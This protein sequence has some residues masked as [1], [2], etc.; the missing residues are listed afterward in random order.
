MSQDN[1]VVQEWWFANAVWCD[2]RTEAK[3]VKAWQW[4]ETYPLPWATYVASI[5]KEIFIH[6]FSWAYYVVL[7]TYDATNPAVFYTLATEATST[8]WANISASTDSQ[9]KSVT[10]ISS[11]IEWG[12]EYLYIFAWEKIHRFASPPWATTLD[13][14]TFS[15]SSYSEHTNPVNVNGRIYFHNTWIFYS[16]DLTASTVSTLLSFTKKNERIIGWSVYN[17]LFRIYTTT[18]EWSWMYIWNGLDT[19]P[20]YSIALTWINVL[21]MVNNWPL[22]YIYSASSLYVVSGT[23]YKLVWKDFNTDWSVISKRFIPNGNGIA[24]DWL[25]FI[26]STS[27][28]YTYW[29]FYAWYPEGLNLWYQWSTTALAITTAWDYLYQWVST[30]LRTTKLTY[31]P[32]FYQW[33]DD[34][35]YNPWVPAT[36][37]PYIESQIYTWDES[38]YGLSYQKSITE[39]NIWY[40][41]ELWTNLDFYMRQNE[42][43]SWQLV[44]NITDTSWYMRIY[45]NELPFRDFNSIQFKVVFNTAYA[46]AVA[47]TPR[48]F[49]IKTIY[50]P[51]GI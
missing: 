21:W 3:C 32:K 26:P 4:C 33:F 38:W 46:A 20:S 41:L 47:D 9:Y 22:D 16:F 1:Y 18:P 39:I 27:G 28:I 34:Q 35:I 25:I 23:Q 13:Y 29:S 51:I 5:I 19:A 48:L 8:L 17:D 2:V 15:W 36:A 45:Q 43:W 42:T 31:K 24:R 30:K 14:K 37:Y 10:G 12:S 49:E 6:Y 50:E 44:K 11:W 40:R 7:W